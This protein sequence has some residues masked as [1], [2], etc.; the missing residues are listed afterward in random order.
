MKNESKVVVFLSEGHR[1]C[2]VG[3][4]LSISGNTAYLKDAFRLCVT[5]GTGNFDI[6]LKGP[7]DTDLKNYYRSPTFQEI[8][9]CNVDCIMLATD[10][11]WEKL[12]KIEEEEKGD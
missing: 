4:L 5:R 11:A 3:K 10:V 8:I 9:L 2:W 6:A 7:K 1:G 12:H